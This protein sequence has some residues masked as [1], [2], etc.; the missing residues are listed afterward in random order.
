MNDSVRK[1]LDSAPVSGQGAYA[2]REEDLPRVIQTL[3]KGGVAVIGGEVWA[4]DG[5]NII[6]AIPRIDGPTR[7][8][9]WSFPPK[10]PAMPWERYASKSGR[11]SL[12]AA[13]RLTR[14][15]DIHP[16]VRERLVVHL[17]FLSESEYRQ[18]HG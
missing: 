14:C 9:G 17:Y 15:S 12:E 13:N 16:A 2:W 18:C 8:Y 11:Q 6:A 3:E 5:H 7:Q 1:L 10:A 4:I